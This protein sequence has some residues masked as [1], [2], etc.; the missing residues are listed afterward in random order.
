[1]SKFSPTEID[2]FLDQKATLPDAADIPDGFFDD[3]EARILA[4]ADAERTTTHAI[5][6]KPRSTRRKWMYAAAAAILLFAVGFAIHSTHRIMD[7][8]DDTFDV[9]AVTDDMTDDDID[10]LDDLFEADIFLTQF[11]Q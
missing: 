7:I 9:Y 6:M 10:E 4:A 8:A 11:D 2:A 3:M 1:M 5:A